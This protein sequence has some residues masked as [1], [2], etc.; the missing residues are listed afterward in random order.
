MTTECHP[1][2]RLGSAK[3][4]SKAKP[5]AT[6]KLKLPKAVG[7]DSNWHF[8]LSS[9]AGNVGIGFGMQRFEI[10]ALSASL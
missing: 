7:L 9:I 8:L 2:A 10:W 4:Q 5:I 6:M 3:D 1:G